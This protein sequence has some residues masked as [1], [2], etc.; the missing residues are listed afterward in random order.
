MTQT[1]LRAA[2]WLILA[3]GVGLAAVAQWSAGVRLQTNL[4]A[5][6]PV[7]ERNPVAE[8][9]LTQ[10]TD[11][12][13][14]RAVFMVGASSPQRSREAARAFAGQ[15][16]AKQTFKQVMAEIPPI[17]PKQ[18]LGIY[19]R[20]RFTLLSAE[21]RA[22]LRG[23]D[24]D[25][26][27][28]LQR[29]LYSP[30]RVGVATT[31][32]DDPFGFLDS[33]LSRVPLGSGKLEWNNGMLV[34]RGN[35]KTW[36]LVTGELPGSAY[37]GDVQAGVMVTVAEAEKSLRQAFPDAEV[38][39]TGAVFYAADARESAKR[40]VD[41]IGAGS[42]IGML[43]LL[44]VVF[45]S[46]RPLVLGLIS[47]GFGV[48]TATVATLAVF[49]ELHLITLVFGASLI[50]EAIDYSV[51][52]FAARLGSGAGWDAPA[53]LRRILP[54]LS[55]ALATSLL[56]YAAL[57]L[58]P[59]PALSQI[60]LFAFSGLGAAWLTV[61]LLLPVFLQSADKRDGARAA[62]FPRRLLEQWT[63]T[64]T[65]RTVW[66]IAAALLAVSAPGWLRLQGNDDIRLLVSRPADLS[67]QEEKIRELTGLGGGGQFFLVEGETPE[68][69]LAAEERLAPALQTLIKEQALVR[70]VATSAFV[71]SAARQNE[72][73]GLLQTAVF[74]DEG[75][76][77]RLMSDAGVRDDVIDEFFH[78]SRASSGTVMTIG[79]WLASPIALPFK[80]LWLG[81]TD[82]GIASIVQ[83]DGVRDVA[84][85][86]EAAAGIRGVTF[87]DKAGSVSQLFGAYRHWGGLWLSAALCLVLVVLWPRYGVRGAAGVLMPTVLSMAATLGVLGYVG[88]PLTL[89]NV[90]G[91]MLVL[92]VG[93]N[94]AIFLREGGVGSGAALA[95]VLLSAGTTLLSFGLLA[96]SSMPALSGFGTTLL[97]GI[98][99]S[100]LLAP[101]SLV[102]GNN[103][104]QHE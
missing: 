20:H 77:A 58:A 4:L 39:R 22:R 86:A 76:V 47:V 90:M 14:N 60:A 16:R 67:E 83:L 7:T 48:V 6:L 101:I 53:G 1:R 89:F 34:S 30:F 40:E 88:S 78:A 32:A 102:I 36:V 52:Y 26:E 72:N 11:A 64:A 18:L 29:K 70:F 5:L 8:T 55:L 13:G 87:V 35:G 56:G 69:V 51:Q 44:Y 49:K 15:L 66:L 42:L 10:L 54:G 2:A 98:A 68:A 12:V 21:D 19:L 99:L 62:A 65:K 57:M 81:P 73:R 82:H 75:H 25:L 17:A 100:T 94:Y 38:L 93:V 92:G 79:D 96:F 103:R 45:R 37:D 97:L 84:R 80:H 31:V 28:R 43:L 74:S 71:P 33:W 59:F 50:G 41:L 85:V 9:A 46:I 95:G 63:R 24:A 3:F 91:L 23:G 104:G 61:V 27:Q